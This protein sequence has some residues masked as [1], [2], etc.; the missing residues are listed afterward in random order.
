MNETELDRLLAKLDEIVTGG[1]AYA[2]GKHG[3][4][5]LTQKECRDLA[6]RI[7]YDKERSWRYDQLSK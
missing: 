5:Y 7:R 1:I 4:I 3:L 6:E 2:D